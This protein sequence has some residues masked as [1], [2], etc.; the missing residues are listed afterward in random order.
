[1]SCGRIHANPKWAKALEEAKISRLVTVEML[2]EIARTCG[3]S[4]LSIDQFS[5]TQSLSRVDSL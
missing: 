1:M 4:D 5:S 3:V 2:G